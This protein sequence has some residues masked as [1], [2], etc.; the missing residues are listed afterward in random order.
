M[1]EHHQD[2]FI[3][4]ASVQLPHIDRPHRVLVPARAEKD[5][6]SRLTLFADYLHRARI[7]W[8][9][10]DLEAYRDYLLHEYEG[11]RGQPLAPNS[12]KAHL[13]TIRGRYRAIV[14][15]PET[16]DLLYAMTPQNATAADKKAF[17]DEMIERIRNAIDPESA[18]VKTRNRQDIGDSDHVRLTIAE[19]SALMSAPGVRT[20]RG[21]RDTAVIATLL[22][23]GLR[24]AEL[25]AL[26][27]GDLRVHLSGELA[28]HVREGKGAKERLVPYGDLAFCLTIV[29]TWLKAAGIERGAVFRGF[30]KGAKRVRKTRLTTRAVNYILEA[31]P[32]VIGDDLRTARP[33]DLRRTYARRLY[34]AGVDLLAIRDNLGHADV[35]TTLK[36]IG[37]MDVEQRR[38]PAMYAFDLDTLQAP[39]QAEDSEADTDRP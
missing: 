30:Y 32:I 25:C 28:L 12:V 26:D 15:R 27:V 4:R 1:T 33:H 2:M 18:T 38:P 22:C 3:K 29:E 23:T 5:E 14:R 39:L 21:L 36:Y 34:D 31:Y 8:F 9:S 6:K 35:K 24:E 19:A 7:P 17:V 16:R 10:P 11:V 20:L 37:T 13:S